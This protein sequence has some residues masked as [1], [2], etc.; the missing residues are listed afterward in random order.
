VEGDSQ[1]ND[2]QKQAVQKYLSCTCGD[3]PSTKYFNQTGHAYPDVSA[4]AVD[5][6]I[7]YRDVEVHV[8]GTS[9]AAPTFAGVVSLLN[10]VRLSNNQ[11][12]LGF[13]N[14]L[15]YGKLMG[16]GFVDVNE[17]L[18]ITEAVHWHVMGSKL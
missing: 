13:M 16:K 10:D 6:A 3:A 12:T 7:Y 17:G 5:F 1:I 18:G 4:Y 9:C 8:S 14:P 2:Y 15:L 11:P